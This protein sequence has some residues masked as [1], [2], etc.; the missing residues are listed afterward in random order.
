LQKLKLQLGQFTY[1]D[2][3]AV[4][5]AGDDEGDTGTNIAS[6]WNVHL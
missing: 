5:A 2:A 6:K 4:N 1:K 3:E